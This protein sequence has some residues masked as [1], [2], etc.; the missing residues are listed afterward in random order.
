MGICK[1][2]EGNCSVHLSR[3][4]PIAKITAKDK[5]VKKLNPCECD[6]CSCDDHSECDC[7]DCDCCCE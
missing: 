5:Y 3:H 1:C 6:N 7:D 2:E 4:T